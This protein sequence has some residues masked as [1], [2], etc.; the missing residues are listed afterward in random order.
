MPYYR[1]AEQRKHAL[2]CTGHY[3]RAIRRNAHEFSGSARDG[4]TSNRAK[5][6]LSAQ[7]H[8]P[9]FHYQIRLSD[10]RA[11]FQVSNQRYAKNG[12]TGRVDRKIAVIRREL[13]EKQ[14]AS[15]ATEYDLIMR[16]RL[17]HIETKHRLQAGLALFPVTPSQIGLWEI[18][19]DN[20]KDRSEFAGRNHASCRWS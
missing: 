14:V 4:D 8:R 3:A 11:F 19:V 6:P 15:D 7:L 2:H 12:S 13:L 16:C 5:I 9:V 18:P 20:R 17:W 10:L 1:R